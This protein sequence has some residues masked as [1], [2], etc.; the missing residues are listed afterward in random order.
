MSK[1][2][3]NQHRDIATPPHL[4]ATEPCGNCG[5]ILAD[6]PRGATTMS[7]QTPTGDIL[8]ACHKCVPCL[9]SLIASW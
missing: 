5:A 2:H 9:K 4:S 7:V 3:R 6:A 8:F 1:R